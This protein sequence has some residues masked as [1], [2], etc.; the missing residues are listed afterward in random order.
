M[1]SKA[2]V[3]IAA[4]LKVTRPSLHH[5]GFVVGS[6]EGVVEDFS[7]SMGARWDGRIFHDS[8]QVVRVAF[9]RFDFP[10]DPLLELVEPS[11]EN[12]PVFR[13]LKR[14]GGLHHLCYE[15]DRLEEQ[16]QMGRAVG[17]LIVKSPLP[18]VAF[19]G[20]RIAWLF[21]KTGLLLEYLERSKSAEGVLANGR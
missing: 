6:I 9:F 15:V 7:L 21:T 3:D 8:L 10:G 20:R 2:G 16:V 12:S 17:A 4:I 18:A 11:A 5:I 13:F 19:E 14:G 1:D